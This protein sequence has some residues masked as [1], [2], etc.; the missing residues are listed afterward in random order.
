MLTTIFSQLAQQIMP[1]FVTQRALYEARERPSKTYSWV[2]FVLSNIL[3]ETPW[4]FF[5]SI[6]L[7]FTWYYPIGLY[8][9]AEP[10]DTVHM[11]G[12]LAWLLIL[13]FI[14]FSSTFAHMAIAAIDNAETGGNIA[15]LCFSLIL[16][17]CGVLAGPTALPRFWIFMYRISP[18][19]Y[20]ISGLLS[21]AIAG[22]KVKCATEEY[23]HFDPAMNMTCGEYLENY[24]HHAGGYVAK[25]LARI[26]C[27]FCPIS[28]TDTFLKGL[29]SNPDEEWTNFGLMW[30]YI[31]F[32]I[33]SAVV[34]YWA[35]RVPK[36]KK[37]Q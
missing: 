14:L 33:V 5:C 16:S 9:N 11:R 10:T 32:N 7:Y 20:F 37:Q 27:A 36:K 25:P 23:L 35:F 26:D 12:A 3:V 28:D 18:L 1:Q 19:H 17:F 30:V 21:A 13:T 2:A 4:S 22:T 29:S 8:R 31:I 15:N 6:L 34:L 24:I